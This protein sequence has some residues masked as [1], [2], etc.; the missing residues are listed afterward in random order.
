[1]KTKRAALPCS[2]VAN[3]KRPTRARA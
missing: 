1:V 2:K 3:Q